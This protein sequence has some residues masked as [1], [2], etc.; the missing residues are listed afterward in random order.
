ML[1][2]V[3][4]MRHASVR[5]QCGAVGQLVRAVRQGGG[6]RAIGQDEAPIRELYRAVGEHHHAVWAQHHAVG[7]LVRTILQPDGAGRQLLGGGRWRGGGARLFQLRQRKVVGD[8]ATGCMAA[9]GKHV[10][11]HIHVGMRAWTHLHI[12]YVAWGAFLLH[13]SWASQC[14]LDEALAILG[15]CT[16]YLRG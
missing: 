6:E 3:D 4:N 10:E 12:L 11:M 1:H 5:Q 7:K 2:S 8:S 15:Q 13:A 14:P 9:R 16:Q